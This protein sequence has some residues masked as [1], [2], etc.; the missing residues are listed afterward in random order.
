MSRYLIIGGAGFLGIHLTKKILEHKKNKVDLVDNFS[1]GKKDIFFKNILIN[2]NV[3]HYNFDLSEKII[4]KKFKKNYDYIFNLAAIVGVKNVLENPL[5]VLIKNIIIQKNSIEICINQKRLKRF[6]F[7]STSEVYYASLKNK[8]IRFPTPEDNVITVDNHDNPRATYM[9]S[10]IYCEAITG[11]AKINY[12]IVR[13]HNVYGPRMGM[14]H[15][16]PELI[17]KINKSNS[18]NMKIL[19]GNF[20]RTFCF[21]DDAINMILSLTYSKKANKKIFNIG[22]QEPETKIIKIAKLI[23]KLENKK[24]VFKSVLSKY[25]SPIRRAPNT[26]KMYKFIKKIKTTTLINGLKKT[27]SWYKENQI[28]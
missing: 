26:K 4:T 17:F 2:K 16:I 28:K 19:N 14:A 5:D 11:L 9:L 8:L 18:K 7:I 13:P 10:K 27:L 24:I 22:I 3:R 23:A 25:E 21:I 1:R 15:V 20:K 12:T 6:I